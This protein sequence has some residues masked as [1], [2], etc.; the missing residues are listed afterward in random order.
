MSVVGGVML[1]GFFGV[2]RSVV[3]MALGDV[4]MVPG[5]LMTAG[6]VVIRG[7]LVMLCSML[8]VFRCFAMML[9]G[10]FRHLEILLEPSA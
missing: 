1:A 9:R 7:G 6:F 5:L 10:I 3:Q 4:G 2:M 8:V